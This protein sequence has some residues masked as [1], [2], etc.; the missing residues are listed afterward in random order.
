MQ[1]IE[2]IRRLDNT[3]VRPVSGADAEFRA[4]MPG[5]VS[6]L[7]FQGQTYRLEWNSCTHAVG[8]PVSSLV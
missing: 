6:E 1:R 4:Y 3:L 7:E 5:C 8:V 2:V